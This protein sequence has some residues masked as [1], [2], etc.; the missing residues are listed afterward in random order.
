[1]RHNFPVV[2]PSRWIGFFSL[3]LRFY[4]FYFFMWHLQQ[5]RFCGGLENDFQFFVFSLFLGRLTVPSCVYDSLS[6]SPGFVFFSFVTSTISVRNFLAR[7]TE[8]DTLVGKAIAA[9]RT[10][11]TGRSQ[12]AFYSMLFVSHTA[13]RCCGVPAGR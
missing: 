7:L 6:Y 13:L 8:F 11:S 4:L 3:R 2:F 1:M 10:F 9:V 5:T 12:Q